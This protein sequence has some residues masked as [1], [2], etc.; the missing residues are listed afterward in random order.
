MPPPQTHHAAAV[1]IRRLRDAADAAAV[2]EINAAAFGKDAGP[3]AM[4]F[5]QLRL[6]A[7]DVVS[8]VAEADAGLVGHAFFCPVSIECDTGLIE[9]MGLG[10]LAVRPAWQSRGIGGRL[11]LSGFDILREA[12]CP[13]VV[14]IGHAEYYPRLGFEPGS[15]HG[16]RCQWDGVPADNFMVKMLDPDRMR[17]VS[18]VATYRD[19]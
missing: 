6:N 11:T 19:V 3:A 12:A 14:V 15:A 1:T 18:G 10:E 8:L 5:H 16:L 13:F 9:G 7:R 4:T 2:L 17:A